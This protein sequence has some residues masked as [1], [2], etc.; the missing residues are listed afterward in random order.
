M[1]C[2]A[3]TSPG[4][5]SAACGAATVV[6]QNALVTASVD[7]PSMTDST[8]T[9]EDTADAA[10]YLGDTTTVARFGGID[11]A[12]AL[13]GCL[14]AAG[15]PASIGDQNLMM[16]GGGWLG[17][18]GNGVRVQVPAA[19]VARANEVIADY[20]AGAFEI[21][22]DPDPEL[23]PPTRSTELALWGPDLSAFLSLWLTPIFGATLHWLNSRKLG[24][25]MLVRRANAGMVL[26]LVATAAAFWL[27]RPR[28]WD[29]A[30][31]FKISG[32]M[33]VYT[34]LWYLVIAHSQSRFIAR[35]FGH[36]YPHRH[37][38]GAAAVGF[39]VMLALGFAG[40]ALVAD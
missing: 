32:L 7:D 34:A 20:R 24:E 40:V 29:A 27:M 1:P 28:D 35:S 18:V 21:E 11:E 6:L 25:A 2:G 33:S 5:P 31:P 12:L 17:G 15:I 4:A 26:S 10:E 8:L 38:W 36:K 16:Q 13:K 14:V 23:A 3:T 9:P 19:L 39:G 37:V 30:A 22:G